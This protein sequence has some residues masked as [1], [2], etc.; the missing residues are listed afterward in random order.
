MR[1]DI[2]STS[3]LPAAPLKNGLPLTKPGK[4]PATSCLQVSPPLR[5]GFRN[6]GKAYV[7]FDVSDGKSCIASTSFRQPY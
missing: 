6:E 3:L 5:S 4:V 7:E 2:A 1:G